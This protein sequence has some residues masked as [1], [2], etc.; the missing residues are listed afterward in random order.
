MSP[1]LSPKQA[2]TLAFMRAF[3]AENDSFPT[4]RTLA[5]HFGWASNNAAYEHVRALA[6][7]GAIE[8]NAQGGWRFTRAPVEASS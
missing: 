4:D 2:E 5:A 8:R 6:R 7:K 3:E 1:A